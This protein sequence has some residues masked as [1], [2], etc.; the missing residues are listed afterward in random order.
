MKLWGTYLKIPIQYHA[1]CEARILHYLFIYSQNII[2][3]NFM[4]AR[5]GKMLVN[6]IQVNFTWKISS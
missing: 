4:L 1:K 5:T 2:K 3:I 6:K